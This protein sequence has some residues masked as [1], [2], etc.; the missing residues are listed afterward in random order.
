MKAIFEQFV[1]FDFF[2]ENKQDFFFHIDK[3]LQGHDLS[4]VH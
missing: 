1:V 3:S 2:D 4:H